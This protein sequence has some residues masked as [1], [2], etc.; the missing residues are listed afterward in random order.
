MISCGLEKKK[1]AEDSLGADS[2]TFPPCK[3]IYPKGED[4]K[5]EKI[6]GAHA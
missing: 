4:R 1:N 3:G 2:D 6:C 5:R